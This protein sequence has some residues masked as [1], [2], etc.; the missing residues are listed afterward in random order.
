MRTIDNPPNPF[1]S[2]HREFLEPAPSVRLELYEDATREI[3]S[4]NDSP[5]LPFRW[6]L[7]PYRGCFHA[8]AYCYARPTH[9]YWG[10]GAGTDFES[11]IIVKRDAP[12]L[13]RQLFDKP[14]WKG[15]LIV[16]SGN[17]DCYQPAEASFGLTRACL[18]ICADYRNPVGIITKGVLVLRDRE[19]LER[20]HKEAWVR[21]YFSIPFADDSVAR[22][23]EPH[24]PSSQKRFE[25][26]TALAE[27]GI[28]TG[29]SVSPIIPGLN[30]EDI[31]DLLGRAKQAGAVE[32]MAT[33]LRLSGPVEQVFLARMAEAFPERVSKI[34][35]R[36]QE[37]R[38]G[39]MTNG[40]FFA[41]HH[42][43]GHYWDMVEQ[44]FTVARRKAGFS[45][46]DGD[47]VPR[48]FRRPGAEQMALF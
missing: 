35:H 26:M 38:D 2:Q 32:A 6:S 21:V 36:I 39:A 11:K 22:L 9:E 31:P 8:C 48:T 27:A 44:L 28:S 19:V 23:V 34:K 7:N 24:A 13:L 5:D 33:L 16:F 14:S 4:R 15:D 42:G 46:L 40:A 18:E 47:A 20:L 25:A 10:F 1:E 30:D 41:R 17:T 45:Q 29:I 12:R 43:T 37:V 3:L